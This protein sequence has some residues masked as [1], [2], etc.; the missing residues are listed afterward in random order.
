MVIWQRSGR[1]EIQNELIWLLSSCSELPHYNLFTREVQLLPDPSKTGGFHHMWCYL[2]TEVWKIRLTWEGQFGHSSGRES[3][4]HKFWFSWS[5]WFRAVATVVGLDVLGFFSLTTVNILIMQII[6]CLL[7]SWLAIS[8]LIIFWLPKKNPLE[9]GIR[10]NLNILVSTNIL[11]SI[12]VI[13]HCLPTSLL[14]F[15]KYVLSLYLA[16]NCHIKKQNKAIKFQ[17]SDMLRGSV[18]CNGP[19]CVPAP[20]NPY[21]EA[22]TPSVMVLGDEILKK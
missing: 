15:Y 19:N 20:H 3:P 12:S 17:W 4:L 8:F 13:S 1:N 11:T 5:L 14:N 22:L 18:G 10:A 7:N 21:V 6:S 9:F 16:S 2:V